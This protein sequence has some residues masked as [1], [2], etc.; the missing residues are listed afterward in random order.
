MCVIHAGLDIPLEGY[1]SKNDTLPTNNIAS[2][3]ILSD[4]KKNYILGM[5]NDYKSLENPVDTTL[6]TLGCFLTN[7]FEMKDANTIGA[8]KYFHARAN[9]N[10]A[11]QGIVGSTVAKLFSDL[12]E[13]SDSY[14]N[15]H[16][17]GYSFELSQKDIEE[18]QQ[19]NAE[20][21]KLGRQYPV[22]P[23]YNTLK[24]F[25]PKG[26]PDRYKNK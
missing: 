25:M 3:P 11:Q 5:Y 16:K 9:Y 2:T 17:K 14:R 15:T 1:I 21:R 24:H 22:T 4:N 23:A 10:A 12:R 7:Y 19:A 8:D 13:Y 26:F 20:G 6:Y 18:D